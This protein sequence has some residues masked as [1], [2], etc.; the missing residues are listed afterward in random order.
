MSLVVGL[1]AVLEAEDR[2]RAAVEDVVVE[3]VDVAAVDAIQLKRA[4]AVTSTRTC[5]ETLNI[6]MLGSRRP[7]STNGTAKL[8]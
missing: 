1:V 7:H 8:Q 4:F 5:L 6:S 2:V 3:E